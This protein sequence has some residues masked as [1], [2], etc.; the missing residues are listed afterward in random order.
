MGRY[1]CVNGQVF[2]SLQ[3]E[4]TIRAQGQSTKKERR[5]SRSLQLGSLVMTTQQQVVESGLYFF[6]GCASFN[7]RY[8]QFSTLSS[9]QIMTLDSGARF[10]RL[11]VFKN[12]TSK[13]SE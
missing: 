13:A 7:T 11:S 6:L 3:L 5:K 2:L 12:S 9:W 10:D 1:A 8:L 4:T